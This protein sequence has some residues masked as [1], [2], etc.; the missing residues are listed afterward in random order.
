MLEPI[1][2][3]I[4]FVGTLSFVVAP[5]VNKAGIIRRF[6]DDTVLKNLEQEKFNIYAQIKEADFEYEMGK[7][8]YRDYKL[9][10]QELMEKAGQ[11]LDEIES[12][13]NG[14]M[15]ISGKQ[16]P[17][18]ASATCDSCGATL[19]ATAKFCSSCGQAT[20]QPANACT[21]CGTTNPPESQFCAECGTGLALA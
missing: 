16:T 3:F 12:Q 5:L 20:S 6:T 7:L 11:V 15:H 9:Q 13:Q 21:E 4:V 18:T 2:T 1:L 17:Q 10:R 14:E 8:S 19:P